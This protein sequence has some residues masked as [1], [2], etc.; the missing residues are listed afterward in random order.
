MHEHRFR[1]SGLSSHAEAGSRWQRLKEGLFAGCKSR[2]KRDTRGDVF[3]RSRSDLESVGSEPEEESNVERTWSCAST[4]IT[5]SRAL[6]V[7][8]RR[9]RSKRLLR[10]L[11]I[12]VSFCFITLSLLGKVAAAPREHDTRMAR[13]AWLPVHYVGRLEYYLAVPAPLVC[14]CLLSIW[15]RLE[16]P[17]SAGA[18]GRQISTT[19]SWALGLSLA[20]LALYALFGDQVMLYVLL[21]Y[22][23]FA[24]G[25]WA[26]SLKAWT[27]LYRFLRTWALFLP[28]I[29][30]YKVMRNWARYAELPKEQESRAYAKLHAKYAPKLFDLLVELG[31]IFVK[32][33]QLLSLLPEGVLPDPFT[34]ELKKLQRA[35]P[36]RGA[37]EV[38]RLVQEA[39][40]RPLESVFSH[41]DNTPIGSASIGQVHKARLLENGREVVVK[42]QYPEV[43]RTI[44]PDFDSC[45]S[46][47]WWLD[48]TRVDEVREAKVHYIKELDFMLEARTL[49]R[50]SNSLRE[51]FPNVKVPVPVFD[52]CAPTVLVMTFVK[53]VSLLDTIMHMAEAIA[54]IR[55]KS[56]DEL[57]AEMTQT[58]KDEEPAGTTE[59]AVRPE[60]PKKKSKRARLLSILRSP[61]LPGVSDGAKLKLLQHCVSASRNAFN[62]GAL[63]YNSSVGLLGA[64]PLQYR[65]AMPNFDPV[66]LSRQ[67]WLVHGHQLL[68]EGMFNTD[69]HP[70]NVLVDSKGNLGLIDFGQVCELDLATRLRFARLVIALASG[71]EWEI[72]SCNAALGIRTENMSPELLS[73]HAKM[74]FGHADI[75]RPQ[76]FDRYAELKT[77]DPL[78]VSQYSNGIG[79]AERLVNILRGISFILGVSSSHCVASVWVDMAIDLLRQHGSFLR[80]DE[81]VV[82]IRAE[83][84]VDA[85][86]TLDD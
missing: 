10:G 44:E 8:P 56:V 19:L 36:P 24:A 86:E 22:L 58:K 46:I 59:V 16:L 74:R 47:V 57:I 67:L 20:V 42:V 64:T 25:L 66:E 52:L 17:G 32:I 13:F 61:S 49:Q 80:M 7:T 51:Q 83:D 79:R 5:T 18:V 85:M 11:L 43:S 69:P 21:A 48:K 39:L 38:R 73:L 76:A 65:Q 62:L 9:S 12:L 4:P 30:E 50:M 78:L 77:K 15:Q 45:E 1:S 60:P 27:R 3:C 23:P 71:D 53:G 81:E 37:E 72:A 40:G 54:K 33:G 29:C 84:F 63:L 75:L 2:R 55:G 6:D 26:N 70:G 28:L 35:V 14:S 82:H 41:F 31:G 68:I 34:R